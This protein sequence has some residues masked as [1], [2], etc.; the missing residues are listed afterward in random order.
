[1]E[2]ATKLPLAENGCSKCLPGSPDQRLRL[3]SQWD[4]ASRTAPAPH[5]SL[6][7]SS[8]PF[9]N[10][11]EWDLE[12]GGFLSVPP[13]SE[14]NKLIER[15]G[16]FS[17][18]ASGPSTVTWLCCL[19]PEVAQHGLVGTQA[20]GGLFASWGEGARDGKG[21]GP[22]MCCQGTPPMTSLSQL[23]LTLEASAPSM[24]SHPGVQGPLRDISDPNDS[25]CDLGIQSALNPCDPAQYGR[26][27]TAAS[28]PP[29]PSHLSS[30]EMAI[31]CFPFH[32]LST[33]AQYH[34]A[35]RNAEQ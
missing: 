16:S 2:G 25:R 10:E 17:L 26:T 22:L 14:I 21:R 1:M 35:Q 28:S 30:S 33:T 13:R 18:T 9:S 7:P 24:S 12:N 20:R 3:L 8:S 4:K 15:K 19:G 6:C 11:S 27:R 32:F 23:A 5:P 34:S 29:C 31:Y